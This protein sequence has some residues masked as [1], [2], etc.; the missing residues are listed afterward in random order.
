MFRSKPRRLVLIYALLIALLLPSGTAFASGNPWYDDYIA[1]NN[2]H[3]NDFL[4]TGDSALLAWGESYLL[5]SYLEMYD[6]TKNTTWLDKFKTHTDAAVSAATDADGDGY[7]GWHTARYSPQ[8][9]ANGNFET[10]GADS[11]TPASWTRFQSTSTTAYRS[12]APG[13]FVGSSSACNADTYGFVLKTNGTS[14][15]KLYQGFSYVPNT[16]YTLTLNAKTNGSAAEGRA[17]VHDRTTNTILASI[18]INDTSWGSYKI[19]FTTPASGHT[20]ELWLGH[21]SYTVSNGIA[22]FDNVALAPSYPF[23]VHD[24][25]MG[26]QMARFVRLVNQNPTG[27]SVYATAAG[28]YQTFLENEVIPKWQTSSSQV[29]NTWVNVGSTEGYYKE[30]TKVNAFATTTVLDPLPY[31]Q[32]LVFAQMLLA[33]H[34]VTGNTAYLDKATR[35]NNYFKNRLSANGT[36]YNWK[37]AAYQSA[38]SSEDTSHGNIDID[39]AL[40]MFNAGLV[41]TGTDM[42]KFTDTLTVKMWN[43][44]T[45]A[46]S[47]SNYVNGTQGSLCRNGLYNA[48][49]PSWVKLAQFDHNAWKIAAYQYD[50]AGFTVDRHIEALVL[51]EIMKW[52]PV[53]LVNQGFELKASDDSTRPSRWT[54][55]GSTASTAY[56]DSANKKSGKYGLTLKSNGT[57]AQTVYQRWDE[58]VASATYVVTFDGKADSSG[59]GGKVWMYNET[60]GATLGSVTF[61]GTSWQTYTFSFTAPAGTSDVLKLYL[62]H[63]NTSISNGLTTFDNVVIKR[64]GDS[65]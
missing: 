53:K 26:V 58:E 3:E 13:N 65:W 21:N 2:V 38:V 23:L 62:G 51:A 54:R 28:N 64:S 48:D 14:W 11:L 25:M 52:D 35:M 40:D 39:S 56:M 63:N 37:Y 33:L 1:Y 12:S 18:T 24:A 8:A 36:A 42:E 46:P 5:G 19:S 20:L 57:S 61:S 15:Q 16:I 47:L 9:I 49:I 60:T 45:T 4:G 7:L 44:S 22:Y 41:F 10:A 43:Q 31:N 32:F 50:D 55:V 17:Y 59:A 6:I 34:D 27:L 30:S 29:G